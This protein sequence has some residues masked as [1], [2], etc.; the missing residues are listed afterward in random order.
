MSRTKIVATIGPASNNRDIIRRL[1]HAGMNVARINFSHGDHET[2]SATIRL[3]RDV[4]KE[5]RKVLAILG[6]LQGPKLRLGRFESFTVE[7]G[8][9]VTITVDPENTEAIFLPH[10]ELFEALQPGARLVLGDGEMELKIFAKTD[11]ELLCT[12]TFNGKMEQRKGI[13]TPGTR[14]PIESI[15]EKDKEDLN[16]I[17]ALNLDFVAMSFVRSGEDIRALRALMAEQD[18]QIA[19]IAKIEKFEAIEEL[20]GIAKEADGL[21]VARGDLGI[22]LPPEQVPLIQKRIIRLGNK[23]GKPVITATQML[24][25]MVDYPRPTRAEASDVANAVLDGTDAVMLS[26][27]TA[28]GKYPVESVQMMKNIS[29]M[30]ESEFP[31][32]LWQ[33]KRWEIARVGRT[34]DAIS[35][36]SCSIAERIGAKLIVTSTMSGYTAEQ[37]SR[38]RP[39]TPILAVSPLPRTQR[40]LALVW[41]VECLM[42]GHVSDTDEMI[43]RTVEAVA[44]SMHLEAGDKLVMTSGVPFGRSGL[45][46]LVQVHEITAE[47]VQRYR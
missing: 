13:N 29:I 19:I 38:H 8:D 37:I 31:Y 36:A 5:E 21:M 34:S 18:T 26:N 4:A 15:T 41:G 32:D 27:E 35:T 12:S 20:E 45:T 11:T 30:M 39:Q 16:L 42:M 7:A 28:S 47:D 17:C 2:H 1:L 44:S 14:L 22:D 43:E 24:Q 23:L 33:Q 25:S 9:P 40:R 3:L 10:P 6:D 46:N